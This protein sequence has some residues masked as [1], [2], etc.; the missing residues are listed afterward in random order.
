M[1]L[2]LVTGILKVFLIDYFMWECVSSLKLMANL[3]LKMNGWKMSFP[4]GMAYFRG[5][6]GSFRECMRSGILK[7]VVMSLSSIS[8]EIMGV[9]RS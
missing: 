2:Q 4:F 5:R 7:L 6:T 1:I 8:S 9:D 3:A